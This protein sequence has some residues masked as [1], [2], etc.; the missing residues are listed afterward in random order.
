MA[1]QQRSAL[2]AV[3]QHAETQLAVAMNRL[4][5]QAPDAIRAALPEILQALGERYGQAAAALACDW[6]EALR[7]EAEAAGLFVAEPAT[8]PTAERWDA[9]AGWGV[10]PLYRSEPDPAAALTL[11]QGGLTRSVTNMHS[12]TVVG[13][14]RRDS[15]A[16]GWQR[17]TRPGACE[18]CRMLAG[19]G[20]VY[21]HDTATFSSHDHCHCVARPEFG[22]VRDVAKYTPSKRRRG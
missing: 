7:V 10:S 4:A 21:K 18:F 3:T 14:V 22:A 12:D 20:F 13:N 17:Q 15:K 11:L 9:L 2:V 8:L 5:G 16:Q 1:V 19:R 6:Y